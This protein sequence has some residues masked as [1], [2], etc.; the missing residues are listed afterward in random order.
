[1]ANLNTREGLAAAQ[2]EYLKRK[3]ADPAGFLSRR[4]EFGKDGFDIETGRVYETGVRLSFGE[5]PDNPAE[6]EDGDLAILRAV[7]TRATAQWRDM[8][9]TLQ[10]VRSDDDPSLNADGRLKVAARILE[11]KLSEM[12]A[13]RDKVIEQARGE[14]ER[15]EAAIAKAV[16]EADPVDLALHADIRK[17]LHDLGFD[18]ARAA[19]AK[20]IE[21]GDVLTLQA[22]ATAPAWMSGLEVGDGEA[23]AYLDAQDALAQHKAPTH[24]ARST[25]LRGGV[26]MADRAVKEYT[27]RA[28]ALIDFDRARQ[29]LEREA[30]RA[31]R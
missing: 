25:A 7:H 2:A 15:E 19:V 16:R 1:M 13:L 18:K 10:A 17:R 29:L 5:W 21:R 3:A 24:Y 14:I 30:Q 22:V 6:R 20:A 9:D 11:P 26:L 31:A 4:P 28:R 8:V 23:A 12:E 27:K